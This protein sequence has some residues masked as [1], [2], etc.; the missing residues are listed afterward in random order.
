MPP[1]AQDFELLIYNFLGKGKLG[2]KQKK[3]FVDNLIKPYSKGI[4]KM[5]IYRAQL[6]NDFESLKKLLPEVTKKLGDKI[7][8]FI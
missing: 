3:F 2:E 6:K 5:E 8:E 7:Q 1:G 4:A